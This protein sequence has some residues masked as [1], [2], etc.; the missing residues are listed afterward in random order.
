MRNL[1]TH[2]FTY[3]KLVNKIIGFG[4]D[5]RK[6]NQE[7]RGWIKSS[8]FYFISHPVPFLNQGFETGSIDKNWL[9]NKGEKSFK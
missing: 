3:S 7:K 2:R 9:K 1:L 6:I 5:K 4:E 8:E